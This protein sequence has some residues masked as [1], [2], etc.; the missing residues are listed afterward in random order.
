MSLVPTLPL[1]I[2]AS[3]LTAS[4]RPYL[5]D[6][7]LLTR[8]NASCGYCDSPWR[9]QRGLATPVHR[10]ILA[11]LAGLGAERIYLSG[12]E[13]LL[14]PDFGV[15]LEYIHELGM[16]VEVVTNG[17]LVPQQLE[18]LRRCSRVFLSLDGR[19]AVHD[20]QRGRG[21]HREA[22]QALR[23]LSERKIPVVLAALITRENRTEID[24]LLELAESLGLEVDFQFPITNP[25]CFGAE[26]RNWM[27]ADQDMRLALAEILAAVKRGAPVFASRGSYRKALAWRNYEIE[28]LELPGS[29]KRCSAGRYF[30]RIEANGNVY[31]CEIHLGRFAP[32]NAASDGVE[33][34]WRHAQAHSCVDCPHVRLNEKRALFDLR[35][36][37]LWR[38]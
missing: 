21:S 1:R 10:Q 29:H 20:A 35:P 25:A 28:S 30:L 8:C 9:H 37:A 14:H 5:V 12:G 23:L 17:I 38:G 4:P 13:P 31:P 18:S 26:A 36:S 22:I 33:A 15:I 2:L 6:Y 27:P 3:R 19:E 32:K 16:A 34:A 24:W 11:E 7:I